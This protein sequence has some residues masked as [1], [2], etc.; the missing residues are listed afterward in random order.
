MPRVIIVKK[1]QKAQGECGKCNAKIKKGDGYKWWKFRFGGRH[2]RCLKTECAPR[3]S[4]LTQSEF[5]GTLYGIEESLGTAIEDFRNGGEPADLAGT[6]NELAEEL[7]QLGSECQDKLDNMPEGLQQGDTGQLLEN[8]AQ[9]CESKADELES[10]A[11]EIES[12]ELYDDPTKYFE[13]NKIERA[14]RENEDDFNKRVKERMEE[15]NEQARDEAA[16]N[17]EIDLSIE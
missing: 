16:S 1:A 2:V 3:P 6:L 10:A 15:A 8:R 12:V 14:K 11:S 9:E 13:D 17:A 4:D 7:R 5:Y